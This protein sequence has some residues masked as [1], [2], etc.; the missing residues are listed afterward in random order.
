MLMDH[1]V[2]VLL[3]PAEKALRVHA[4]E[5]S[6]LLGPRDST[7]GAQ[8]DDCLGGGLH[9]VGDLPGRQLRKLDEAVDNVRVGRGFHVGRPVRGFRLVGSDASGV[10]MRPIHIGGRA[11]HPQGAGNL[12]CGDSDPE[13]FRPG[14]VSVHG[15]KLSCRDVEP[16][17]L[18]LVVRGVWVDGC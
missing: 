7:L 3:T 4:P 16:D 11:L 15:P 13:P 17:L 5:P 6:K 8:G 12:L 9:D 14:L 1:L 2:G 10:A 18:A